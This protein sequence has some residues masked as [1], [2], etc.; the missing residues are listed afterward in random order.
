MVISSRAQPALLCVLLGLLGQ[1]CV[2][3]LYAL[4]LDRDSANAAAGTSGAGSGL[5]ASRACAAGGAVTEASCAG[6]AACAEQLGIAGGSAGTAPEIIDA[7]QGS[8]WE[9]ATANLGNLDSI[10][11]SS[12]AIVASPA[13]DKILAQ[14]GKHGMYSS[15]DGGA[16]WALLPASTAIS[17]S[18]A[19]ILLDAEHPTRF[20]EIGN[21]GQPFANVTEDGG[22]TFRALESGAT[23]GLDNI[24]IDFG[25]SARRVILVG[26]HETDRTLLR[27]VDGGEV[28]SNI[29]EALPAG[30]YCTSPLVLDANSY[31]VG[32][33]SNEIWRTSN[34]G[35]DWSRVS[36][37]GG[38]RA[39]LMTRDGDVYWAGTRGEVAYSHDRGMTFKPILGEGKGS[40]VPPV[41]LPDGA[42]AVASSDGI[43]ITKDQGV[44]WRRVTT[45]PPHVPWTFTYSKH[46]KAFF[47]AWGTCD[48]TDIVPLDA[49]IK[50]RFDYEQ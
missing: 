46:L 14:I 27:S 13:E 17:H 33:A 12:G 8:S 38:N 45:A 20:W 35:S 39:S 50:F 44:T 40:E 7:V 9:N 37:A 3:R 41:E 26:V 49:I 16:S 29:G 28:W 32:C 34:A 22:S 19:A 48:G 15:T 31:L 43:L 4:E 5:V 42:V 47:A 24:S 25:D 2:V 21:H 18:G 11:G 23:V 1:G 30:V 36:M 10:C 6:G